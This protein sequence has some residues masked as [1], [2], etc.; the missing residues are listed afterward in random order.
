MAAGQ[1]PAEGFGAA[2]D[3]VAA[4]GTPPFAGRHMGGHLLPG[5]ALEGELRGH[6]AAQVPAIRQQQADARDD[7][8]A[9]ARQEFEELRRLCLIR[10]LAEDAAADAHHRIGGQHQAI[11]RGG[12]HRLGLGGGQ[13][14][15][16]G[17]RQLGLAGGFVD[18]G[19]RDPV[20]PDADARQQLDPPRAGGGEHQ[21]R[22][23]GRHPGRPVLRAYLKRKVMRP[24]VRS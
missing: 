8:V 12:A 20:G 7:L 14:R 6:E 19:G 1:E 24:L 17:A 23:R 16:K 22:P 9:T 11:G 10:R 18:V 4:R 21:R 3:L 15:G 5:Q 13:A 2:L